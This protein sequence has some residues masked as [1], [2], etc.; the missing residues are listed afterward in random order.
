MVYKKSAFLGSPTGP[1]TSAVVCYED[2]T[3]CFI[4]ISGDSV[5]VKLSKSP[6]E[7]DQEYICRLLTLENQI[8]NFKTH[9]LNKRKGA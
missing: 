2:P 9:L 4:Q 1:D 7:S 3:Q 8:S 5:M 6:E